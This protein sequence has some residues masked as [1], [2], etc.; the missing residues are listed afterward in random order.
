[1]PHLAFEKQSAQDLDFAGLLTKVVRHHS[2][3][4]L[5]VFRWELC[6]GKLRNVF[7][8][9]EDVLMFTDGSRLQKPIHIPCL[10]IINRRIPRTANNSMCRRGRGRHH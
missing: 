3:A 4:I 9:P 6:E 8:N 1:M 7:S 10:T 2:E 5:R